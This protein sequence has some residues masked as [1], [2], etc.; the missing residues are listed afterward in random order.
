MTTTYGNIFHSLFLTVLLTVFLLAETMKKPRSAPFHYIFDMC[1]C[2]CVSA[3]MSLVMKNPIIVALSNIYI[4]FLNIEV[5]MIWLKNVKKIINIR[6]A[7]FQ[8]A[9][10]HQHSFTAKM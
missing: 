5:T 7:Q 10:D 2:V 4:F 8:S 9:V 6:L 1:V 3:S